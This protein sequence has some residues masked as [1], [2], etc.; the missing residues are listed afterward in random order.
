MSE[1]QSRFTPQNPQWYADLP[2][3][4]APDT[5]RP[6]IFGDLNHV[7][8]TYLE[9]SRA[10]GGMRGAMLAAHVKVVVACLMQPAALKTGWPIPLRPPN[11][12]LD[13]A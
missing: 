3:R 8:E 1:A 10:S 5:D 4:D 13:S 6:A 11:P 12:V 2:E 7:D 9:I